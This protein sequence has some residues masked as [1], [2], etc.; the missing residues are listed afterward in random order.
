MAATLKI[1]DGVVTCDFLGT[2]YKILSSGGWA[3]KRA[4]R[5]VSTMGGRSPY[6]DVD[7]TM[8]IS[9]SGSSKANALANLGKLSDLLDQAEAWGQ[10]ENVTAVYLEYEPDGSALAA[11]VK[12][13]II[14]A[15]DFGPIISEP[16]DFTFIKGDSRY[17]IG[18][19]AD[20]ITLSFKRRGLWLGAT[21]TEVS[22]TSTGNPAKLTSATFTDTASILWP[23]DAGVSFTSSSSAATIDVDSIWIAFANSSDKIYFSEAE[24]MGNGS[25]TVVSGASSGNVHQQTASS[26]ALILYDT[27]TGM[28][29]SVRKA[30]MFVVVK[31]SGTTTN[32]DIYGRAW[33][34]SQ[35]GQ[36]DT[37]THRIAADDTDVQT[38]SLGIVS[39]PAAIVRIELIF[40]PD[41]S[42]SDTLNIDYV[43]MIG[44]DDSTGI[45]NLSADA[46]F[47]PN[48]D[49]ML[50]RH[51]LD[52]D[53]SPIAY[54]YFTSGTTDYHI[55]YTGNTLLAASGSAISCIAWGT[56]SAD[57]IINDGGTE[58][59][60]DLS[61]TRDS[62][63]LTPL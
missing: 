38:I 32:W 49:K 11:S 41:A 14:G 7:E 47:L 36:I 62:A 24:T 35:G 3:P 16:G 2:D 5:R 10:G 45:V 43:I 58:V 29:S 12:A 31:S 19:N 22:S 60:L 4:Q 25:S 54:G 46:A 57:Y 40:T 30:A 56:D 15:S 59:N 1:S 13:V 33:V 8:S 63:Y 34:A 44:I 39:L 48:I 27:S 37:R 9:V 18:H 61:V 53:L 52:S 26:G 17:S 20:P 51:R 21:E 42:N 55:P 50:F 6:T 28:N 23:Y